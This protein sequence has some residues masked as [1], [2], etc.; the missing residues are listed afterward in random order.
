[1]AVFTK[2]IALVFKGT[3]K[4]SIANNCAAMF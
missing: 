3:G 4:P 2:Y 1:L